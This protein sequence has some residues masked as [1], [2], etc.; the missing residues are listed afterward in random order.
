MIKI[1]IFLDYQSTTPVDPRVLEAM[2]PYF[3]QE[4]GNAASKNHAFGWNAMKKVDW[5]RVQIARL[6]NASPSEIIFTSGA[7]ESNN[8]ALKGVFEMYKEKGNHII[9][10]VTE[11]KAVLDSCKYLES[12]GAKI[13]YLPVDA[14]GRIRIDDLNKAITDKTILISIMFANNEIGTLQPIQEIGHIA[15]ID[16]VLFHV[17]AAQAAGRVPIDVEKLGIDILSLSAHK[18]YGP[19]GIGVLYVREKNPRVRLSPVIH[20]GGHER[21]FRSGTLNVPGIV[22]F[23]KAAE[24]AIKEMSAEV[25]KLTS[26]RDKL[27]TGITRELDHVQLNG[28]STERLCNNLN[29]SFGFADSESLMKVLCEE[30][31]V[32]SGSACSTGNPEPSHVLKALGLPEDRIQSSIRFG[33]GRFTTDEEIEY[34]I[35][36][37]AAHVKRLRD[38]S[39]VYQSLQKSAKA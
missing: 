1:P 15:K 31:A 30:V 27:Y 8:I 6:I 19:K 22:G 9:T 24:I 26:L 33:L 5:G 28:H 32:S 3:S 16:H 12:L 18:M 2:L 20:G 7:T 14:S 37:V 29:L 38:V 25:E 34:T 35:K 4:F 11:H 10:Q 17:D 23:G 36:R 13:T 39:P 21:G